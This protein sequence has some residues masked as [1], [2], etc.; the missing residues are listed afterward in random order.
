MHLMIEDKGIAEVVGTME[1]C[2]VHGFANATVKL[3]ES[4]IRK[5][6]LYWDVEGAWPYADMAPFA[7][8]V[9]HSAAVAHAVEEQYILL[10]PEV[11]AAVEAAVTDLEAWERSL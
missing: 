2:T 5:F 3:P 11:S 10:H 9:N 4:P 8:P 6:Q 1:D 7:S